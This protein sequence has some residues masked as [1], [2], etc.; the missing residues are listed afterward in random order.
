MVATELEGTGFRPNIDVPE[1]LIKKLKESLKRSLF[2]FI[3]KLKI[4][5]FFWGSNGGLNVPDFDY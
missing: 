2:F 3:Y 4:T 1:P 5:G